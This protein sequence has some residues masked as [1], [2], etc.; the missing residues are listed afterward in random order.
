[1]HIRFDGD[2]A[3]GGQL[4]TDIHAAGTGGHDENAFIIHL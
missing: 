2:A 4:E 3:F 1:M